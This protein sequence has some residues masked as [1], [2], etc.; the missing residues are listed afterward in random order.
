[1]PRPTAGRTSTTGT[2]VG[3]TRK[4]W[5]TGRA[6]R[7]PRAGERGRRKCGSLPGTGVVR[8]FFFFMVAELDTRGIRSRGHRELATRLHIGSVVRTARAAFLDAEV[9]LVG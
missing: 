5:P 9:P 8:P 1:M 2:R 7:D 3:P 6:L 4:P